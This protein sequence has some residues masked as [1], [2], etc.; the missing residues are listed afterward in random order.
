[1]K[2]LKNKF[3]LG[4]LVAVLAIFALVS[5]K[6]SA[7]TTST[8]GSSDTTMNPPAL[9]VLPV[10]CDLGVGTVY[11]PETGESCSIKGG[12]TITPPIVMMPPYDIN[13]CKPGSPYSMTTGN[14]CAGNQLT[15]SV[16]N[17]SNPLCHYYPSGEIMVCAGAPITPVNGCTSG[18]IF[19]TT[20]GTKCSDIKP[21][22]PIMD[23]TIAKNSDCA[24]MM[25]MLATSVSAKYANDI[26]ID[27]TVKN[28]DSTGRPYCITT[29]DGAIKSSPTL[30]LPVQI[31]STSDMRAVQK[32]LN[33]ALRDKQPVALST[34]GKTGPRTRAAIKLFQKSVELKADG[35][36]GP[37]TLLKLRA[38]FQ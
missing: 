14:K 36:I 5:T 18:A 38:S 1:M 28:V 12:A 3:F 27:G 9:G 15:T 34:D 7:M 23:C 17:N 10:G 31:S 4:S 8:S 22:P 20:T 33:S 26:C 21:M 11:S 16:T 6:A 25:G 19:S 35:I 32:A 37:R 24:N 30:V 29:I 2:T 13:G